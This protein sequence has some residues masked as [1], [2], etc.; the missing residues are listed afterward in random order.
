HI[1]HI[2]IVRRLVQQ[3]EPHELLFH[4]LDA[5]LVA[6]ALVVLPEF[7]EA[8]LILLAGGDVPLDEFHVGL[9]RGW[10]VALLVLFNGV[11]GRSPADEADT[12]SEERQCEDASHGVNLSCGPDAG[13][14]KSGSVRTCRN[15][16]ARGA[17]R[18]ARE[19]SSPKVW[20]SGRRRA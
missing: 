5:L 10:E 8:G 15:P 20:H 9:R 6:G 11:S 16:K 19:R 1:L 18:T 17:T 3:V 13:R 12:E 2:Q 7:L 14:K 4:P